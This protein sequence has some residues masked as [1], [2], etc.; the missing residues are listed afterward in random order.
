MLIMRVLPHP[1][2]G[3]SVVPPTFLCT[4]RLP[5]GT[6]CP[7]PHFTTMAYTVLKTI[8]YGAFAKVNLAH[9]HFTSAPVAVKVFQKKKLWCSLVRSEVDIMM[10]INHPKIIS[11]L[12]VIESQ[13]R[14]YLIMELV[15]GQQLY[16][17]V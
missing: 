5:Q 1:P 4:S 10:T 2:P 15:E 17:Y 8:G 6:L 16:R 12:R 7:E 11:L 14:T 13:K 9:H 3:E